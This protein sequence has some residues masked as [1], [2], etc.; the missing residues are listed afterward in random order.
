MTDDSAP[1]L[2]R[3]WHEPW[4]VDERKEGD[5]ESV[6]EADEPG[7]FHARVYVERPSEH[8]R[9]V[10]DDAYGPPVE[11]G[12]ADDQVLGPALLNL[13][14]LPVVHHAPDSAA[15]VVRALGGVGEQTRQLF[16]HPLRVVGG[17]EIR[18]ALQVVLGEEREQVAHLVEAGLLV[19]GR[20]VGDA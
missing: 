1:L 11:P 10:P 19:G 3:A 13:E 17:P 5:V 18:G 6:A 9:L 14:E 15:D 7:A 4:H 8:G 20:E 12:E 2:I 16:L